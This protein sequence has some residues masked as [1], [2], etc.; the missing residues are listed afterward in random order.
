MFDSITH[1]ELI[2]LQNRL[3]SVSIRNKT[4]IRLEKTNH[5]VTGRKNPGKGIILIKSNIHYGDELVLRVF[6]ND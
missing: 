6:I 4:T 1:I 3:K 2:N 5:F